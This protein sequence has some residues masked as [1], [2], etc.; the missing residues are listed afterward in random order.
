MQIKRFEANDLNEALQMIKEEFGPNA[1]ILS[2]SKKNDGWR[3]FFR[4]AGVVVTAATDIYRQ[5]YGQKRITPPPETNGNRNQDNKKESAQKT[6]DVYFTP[7]FHKTVKSNGYENSV[8]PAVKPPNGSRCA[9]LL[10]KRLIAHGMEAAVAA[11]LIER[12]SGKDAY[13]S[14]T[15]DHDLR[16]HLVSAF[17]AAGVQAAPIESNRDKRRI[18]VMTGPTGVGKTITIAKLAAIHNR[19]KGEPVSVITLD[20][21]RIGA[22]DQM[23]RYAGVIGV[24][25]YSASSREE[26]RKAVASTRPD[27]LVLVDTPGVSPKNK[28]KIERL[29]NI[30]SVIKHRSTQLVVGASTRDADFEIIRRGFEPLAVNSLLYTKIDETDA[31]G[32]L[33]SQLCR[34]GL[35]VSYLTT[36]QRIPEDLKPAETE[37]LA[38]L[39][40]PA[41]DTLLIEAP[42]SP[43]P[44]PAPIPVS[45]KRK[46]YV[47]NSNSDIYHT[48]ECRCAAKISADNRIEFKSR[49]EAVAQHFKPC[50][51]CCARGANVDPVP[52]IQTTPHQKQIAV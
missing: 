19:R 50:K 3:R 52:E 30:L 7:S 9:H 8:K 14:K 40:L 42:T 28:E 46:T 26:L 18:I 4:R 35:P 29:G 11:E 20:H 21:D 13:N 51:H 34:S 15:S 32:A 25:F 47:A 41:G 33:I 44:E 1:V 17:E 36:G 12:V 37:L 24:S 10:K 39:I 23:R 45:V 31:Y 5:G 6:S 43:E 48:A 2:A 16:K 38:E 27:D 22:V 49:H